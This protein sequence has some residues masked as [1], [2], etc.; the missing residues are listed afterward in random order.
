MEKEL[1]QLFK[2]I[3]YANDPNLEQKIWSN[4]IIK[5]KNKINRKMF[6]LSIISLSSFVVLFPAFKL[7]FNDLNQ[8]GFFEYISLGVFYNSSFSYWKELSISILE[9]L[10]MTSIIISS[11]FTFIFLISIKY[12]NQQ[13]N[14]LNTVSIYT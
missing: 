12:I 4:I 6:L 9:S 13:I 3:K 8:S 14:T 7:L 2:K 5:E 10:P 1:T 11:T